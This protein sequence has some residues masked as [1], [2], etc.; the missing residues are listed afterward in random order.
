MSLHARGLPR[1][2]DVRLAAALVWFAVRVAACLGLGVMPGCNSTPSAASSG[3]SGGTLTV[4]SGAMS[5]DVD[6]RVGA[7]IVSLVLGTRNWLTGPTA[8]PTNYGSTFWSSPQSDWNWPPPPEIDSLPYTAS[9]DAATLTLQGMPNPSLGFRVTKTLAPSASP[10]SAGSITIQY[11]LENRAAAPRSVAPWEVTRVRPEGLL[12]FPT[13]TAA[14]SDPGGPPLPTQEASGV[15]WFDVDAASVTSNMKYFADGSRGWVA[16][17]SG[18]FVFVKKF[19][20]TSPSAAAPGESEVEI[21]VNGDRAYVELEVQGAYQAVS[22]GATLAWP[23]RW[24]LAAI[25]SSVEP[26][27]G[28][29]SLVAFV[30]GL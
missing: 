21:Y 16:Q 3:A 11:A 5:I 28:S 9:F 29:A 4:H 2:L 27:L 12:F 17:A 30:D 23:V 1:R 19:A 20:D 10:A 26:T 14:H 13:G 6:P 24:V 25:P 7:R 22:P 8:N 15:T 18:G